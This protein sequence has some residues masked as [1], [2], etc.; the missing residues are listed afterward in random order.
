MKK[1][2]VLGLATLVALVFASCENDNGAVEAPQFKKLIRQIA[3]NSNSTS[4]RYDN[5]NRITTLGT[6]SFVYDGS[7]VSLKENSKELGTFVVDNSRMTKFTSNSSNTIDYKYSSDNRLVE[8]ATSYGVSIKLSWEN[9]NLV[10]TESSDFGTVTYK[11]GTKPNYVN[12][13]MGRYILLSPSFYDSDFWS[14]GIGKLSA[15]LVEEITYHKSGSSSEY[16]HYGTYSYTYELDG[17]GCP[18]KV[19]EKESRDDGE[20]YTNTYSITY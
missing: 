17:D 8:I 10:K 5:S 18:V 7:K 1:L 19:T 6:C 20:V 4:F 9:G 3:T 11:Y 12:G 13:Q 15:N 16:F 14:V 2:F